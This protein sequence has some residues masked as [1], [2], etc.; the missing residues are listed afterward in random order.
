MLQSCLLGEVY[1]QCGKIFLLFCTPVSSEFVRGVF[2]ANQHGG[3]VH[4][5]RND[6]W[7]ILSHFRGCDEGPRQEV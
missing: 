6:F 2:R 1:R 7:R 3:A 4:I 5:S